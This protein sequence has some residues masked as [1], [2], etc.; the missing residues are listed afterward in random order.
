MPHS[1]ELQRPAPKIQESDE[2]TVIMGQGLPQIQNIVFTSASILASGVK[3]WNRPARLLDLTLSTSLTAID[4]H[5]AQ[6]DT[7]SLAIYSVDQQLLYQPTR[8]RHRLRLVL[9]S[10]IRPDGAYWR[11]QR[12][13]RATILFG[14][15]PRL[16]HYIEVWNL[17]GEMVLASGT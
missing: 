9:C 6:K 3:D 13:T 8:C 7:V 2:L 14:E 17:C 1:R 5:A 11:T 15:L 16:K 4:V 12:M 10:S